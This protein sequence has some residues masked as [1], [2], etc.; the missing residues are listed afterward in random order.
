MAR[1]LFSLPD[2]L[3]SDLDAICYKNKFDRSEFLRKLIRDYSMGVKVPSIMNYI[4]EDV[5]LFDKVPDKTSI[6]DGFCVKCKKKASIVE[7]K[8]ED[9][10][11]N[12]HDMWLCK[13]CFSKLKSELST[14]GGKLIENSNYFR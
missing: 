6:E 14:M 4:K 12:K 1:V 2:E 10:E 7:T 9:I 3:L 13:S 5:K 11:G 8:W